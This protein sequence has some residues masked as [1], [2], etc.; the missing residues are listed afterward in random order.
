[1]PPFPV[2]RLRLWPA[3]LL[4]PALTE[5]AHAHTTMPQAGDFVNGALHPLT[6]PAHVLILLGL[7]VALGQQ[8][9]FRP[10]RTLLIF[11]PCA[12][13]ALGF[14]TRF[15]FT[16]PQPALIGIA[17]CAGVLV[18]AGRPLPFPAW[19]VLA[20]AAAV[21]MGLDS[22]VEEAGRAT[23][24]RMLCGTLAG[25][26]IALLTCAFYTSMAVERRKKWVDI[27]LRIV[28]S[29]IAAISVLMLAFAL[30]K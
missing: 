25:L 17:L 27:A 18:A 4:F 28:G 2:R 21:C 1:M 5:G 6:V 3:L 29:W 20:A 11:A 22:G 14:T 12:A 13:A 24:I 16:L 26:V 7:A 9:P 15:T 10:G 8:V 23:E 19:A 30:R